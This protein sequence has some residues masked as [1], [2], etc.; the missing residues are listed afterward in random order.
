MRDSALRLQDKTVLLVGP[1][2]GVTQACLQTLT[3]FGCDVAFVSHQTPHASRYIDGINEAREAHAHYGRAAYYFLPTRTVEEVQEALS[4]VTRTLGRIDCVVD[5]TPL[6]D[7]SVDMSI[8]LA[9]QCVP[10]LLAKQRGRIIFLFEDS[11]LEK[12]VPDTGAS[13][14][15]DEL[16]KRIRELAQTYRG[17]NVTVNAIGVGATDDFILKTMPKSPSIK[18]SV[19]ELRK[20]HP[21]LRLVEFHD[22]ALGVSYFASA[23]SASVTGQVLRL[24]HGFQL[25]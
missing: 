6:A 10:F 9:E 2:G 8:V 5:A 3:Q 16:I 18:K 7:G 1:F 21:A 24:T 13:A 15:R 11:S 20:D 17:K 12:I 23:L 4:Q 19:E 25:D 22:V 14:S